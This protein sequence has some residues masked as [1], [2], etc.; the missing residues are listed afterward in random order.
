MP[1]PVGAMPSDFL[2]RMSRQARA[3]EESADRR[4]IF[5]GCY[6]IMTGNMLEA[7]AA[8]RFRDARWVGALLDL[9]AEYYFDALGAYE[10][11]DPST[12]AVW[13]TT[14]E[15]AAGAGG[16]AVQHLLL[17]VNAHINYD[18]VLTVVELLDAHWEG[19]PEE[20]RAA[21]RADFDLVND[22]IKETIDRVQDEILAK[23]D[24]VMAWVDVLGG[25]FDEWFAGWLISGWRDQVWE[26]A[27]AMLEAPSPEAREALRVNVENEALRR[28]RRIWQ[29]SP[30]AD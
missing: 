12:P 19:L 30:W 2:E 4:A 1:A 29:A 16:R 11:G 5:L 9:F 17:G 18:L 8:G 21:H 13:Q 6:T 22:V 14:H 10:A 27:V 20:R 3:W 7:V 15:A 23:H 24:P 26:A 25:P 28:G